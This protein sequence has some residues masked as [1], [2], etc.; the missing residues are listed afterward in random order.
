[1]ILLLLTCKTSNVDGSWQVVSANAANPIATVVSSAFSTS[2]L[3]A[4][5]VGSAVGGILLVIGVIVMVRRNAARRMNGS[6]SSTIE[7]DDSIS[8][9]SVFQP[10]LEAEGGSSGVVVFL[11]N[12]LVK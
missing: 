10:D 8:E 4:I 12:K 1:M 5:V 7:N 6:T 2:T 3:T 11:N 9:G